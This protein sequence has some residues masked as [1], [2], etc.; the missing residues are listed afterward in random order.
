M[1]HSRKSLSLAIAAGLLLVLGACGDN[2]DD[3]TDTTDDTAAGSTA[4]TV[5]AT[6]FSFDTATLEVEPGATVDLTLQNDGDAPH[7][8]SS[9]DIE[10]D[11]Q[12]DPG[13]SATG[14]FTAPDEDGTYEFHCEV[15]PD[16]TGEIIVGAGEAGSAENEDTTEGSSE[17]DDGY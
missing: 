12:A 14:T 4:V 10:V 13:S 9:G 2:T 16:M 8:F 15:H 7:T 17:N 11:V 5:V 1:P 6:D 3:A